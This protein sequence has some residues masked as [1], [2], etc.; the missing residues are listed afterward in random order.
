MDC[1]CWSCYYVGPYN[2]SRLQCHYAAQWVGR[3]GTDAADATDATN[4]AT[5]HSFCC[6]R[7][8]LGPNQI[9]ILSTPNHCRPIVA[10]GSLGGQ[11][12][13]A[14]VGARQ[15]GLGWT[16]A[17][18]ELT[19]PWS[20]AFRATSGARP[21]QATAPSQSLLSHGNQRTMID[22]HNHP[23]SCGSDPV[24]TS[25][26]SVAGRGFKFLCVQHS[27]KHVLGPAARAANGR[28]IKV[29][30]AISDLL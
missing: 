20:E 10:A 11:L 5:E 13:L 3:E 9:V 12:R 4:S 8:S 25:L 23:A 19:R 29:R 30:W 2:S 24:L 27:V 28:R 1:G 7:G 17:N 21:D 16:R 18:P 6:S 15:A 14:T 22:D 26:Q